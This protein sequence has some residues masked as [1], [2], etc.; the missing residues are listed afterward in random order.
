MHL[1]TRWWAPAWVLTSIGWSSTVYAQGGD[2]PRV[3]AADTAFVLLSTALVMLMTPGLALFYGGMVR[4]KNALATIMQSFI[5]LGLVG[6]AWVVYGY[7]LAFGPDKGGL[8]GGLEWVGLR[9]VGLDPNPDYASTI[10]HQAFMIYQAM[11]AVITPALITGA[12]AERMKFKTYV[13]FVILWFTLVYIP[14]A[15][16]VWGAGGWL[17]SLGALDFAGGT[18]VHITSG[19]SALV[20]AL[21]IGKRLRYPSEDMRPHNVTITL[22]GTGLLWFGWFGFNAGSALSAG[23]LSVVAFVATN[24]AGAAAALAWMF[25]EWWDRGEPNVLGAASGAVA[26]LVGITPAAG[27][28]TPISAIVIGLGAG[29]LCYLAVM[30]LRPALGY[31]DSLDTFG[32]HGVGGVWGALATGL[33]ASKLVNEAGANGLFAGNPIQVLIQLAGVVA[34]V[35]YAALI[36]FVLLKVLEATLG[37]RVKEAAEEEGLDLSEHGQLAYEPF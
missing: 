21:L 26:G 37:L 8:I 6:V 31:D 15:H 2:P 36:T 13:V 9:N 20:A 29:A 10:P 1:R 25:L 12:F 19:I 24:T 27:F 30:K 4:R 33:F 22:L 5:C 14:V 17:R 16:W 35:G 23:K 32:I 34:T 28:V 3:D 11:F 18:V 7:S